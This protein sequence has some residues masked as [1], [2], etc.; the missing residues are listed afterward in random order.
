[1]FFS[2]KKKANEKINS[3][4]IINKWISDD[5]LRFDAEALGGREKYN[6]SM[7]RHADV[8]KNCRFSIDGS[9]LGGPS[10][11]ATPKDKL[12]RRLGNWQASV[13][14]GK[15][16]RKLS[17]RVVLYALFQSF[18]FRFMSYRS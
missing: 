1:M 12:T 6:L 8:R 11:K 14:V 16:A 7:R 10:I 17:D 15:S 13:A 3:N 5:F 18:F 9:A 4:L 2:L